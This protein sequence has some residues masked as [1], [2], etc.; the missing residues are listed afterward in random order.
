MLAV[1][2]ALS[3]SAAAHFAYLGLY[4]PIG[5]AEQSNLPSMLEQAQRHGVGVIRVRE[6]RDLSS[7][8]RLLE[9]RR[10]DTS[11]AQALLERP[12]TLNILRREEEDQKVLLDRPSYYPQVPR[13][14]LVSVLR[15]CN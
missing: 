6:P 3:H 10:C 12:Q 5:C 4:L 15:N 2:E 9:A 14:F 1:H 8:E 13:A 11:P 7:Y